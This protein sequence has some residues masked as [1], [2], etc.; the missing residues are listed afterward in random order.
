MNDIYNNIDK[1]LLYGI[2]DYNKLVLYIGKLYNEFDQKVK[3][4][5]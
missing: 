4:I 2:D 1:L 5:S 3:V